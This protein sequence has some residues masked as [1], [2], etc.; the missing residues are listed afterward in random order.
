[1]DNWMKV[2]FTDKSTTCFGQGNDIETFV[3]CH[4]NETLKK[5]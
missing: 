3:W 2:I 4:F 1:M 5:H